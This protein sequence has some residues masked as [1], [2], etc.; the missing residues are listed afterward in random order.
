[1]AIAETLN[2]QGAEDFLQTAS[3]QYWREIEDTC[4]TAPPEMYEKQRSF[5]RDVIFAQT[6]P[7]DTPLESALD[8][9]CGDG[10]FTQIICDNAR[11]VKAFDLSETQVA[12]A[13]KTLQ[14]YHADV[15]T[16][17]VFDYD[18]AAQLHDLVSCQGVTMY[19]MDD[20]KFFRT[21]ASLVGSCRPGGYILTKDTLSVDDSGL[22]KLVNR[23]DETEGIFKKHVAIYRNLLSYLD[24]FIGRHNC[25]LVQS[26]E[27][28]R[29]DQRQI[30]SRVFLFQVPLP[31]LPPQQDE[32]TA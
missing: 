15:T 20:A 16:D 32:D 6:I 27:I 8:V 3:D 5:L 29:N 26:Q 1:M 19:I 24:V 11:Y 31:T 7:K 14:P 21:V 2:Q 12:K 23:L 13:R 10:R 22:D 25:R 30:V 17:S 9:G 28:Y 18:Y 4:A